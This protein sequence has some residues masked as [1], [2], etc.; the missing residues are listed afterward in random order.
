M[1]RLGLSS[2]AI[3]CALLAAGTAHAQQPAADAIGVTS[4]VNPDAKGVRPDG[5]QNTLMVGSNVIFKER[6]ETGPSGQV[7][8]LFND[9][10]A[11][12][13]GP[14]ARVVIDQF[15]Y[16]PATEPARWR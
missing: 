15:V 5:N 16:N 8:L 12:S 10:S 6:I 11:I 1:Q 4:A 7:Q 3:A 13:V 2:F 14:N 9:Q